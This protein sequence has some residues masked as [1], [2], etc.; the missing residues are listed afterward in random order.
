[1]F[2]QIFKCSVCTINNL[3]VIGNTELLNHQHIVGVSGSRKIDKKSAEWLRSTLK[4]LEP[5]V[6]VSGLA[7]GADTVAHRYGIKNKIKQIAILP[8]GFDNIYPKVN[9]KIAKQIIKDGG[10]LASQLPPNKK[11]SKSSFVKR[12][13]VIAD[14]SS[15]LII[16]QCK[17][18]SGTMHT[19]N[20][21]RN[22]NI[23]IIVQNADYSGNQF[24]LKDYNLS[25]S[26]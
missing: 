6:L 8:S 17:I 9:T 20:F 2:S 1:M 15:K 23:P 25:Q 18:K 21:A 7:F 11:A 3:Y 24:I 10:C 22:N 14:L 4:T 12:N 16:P 5:K 13:K 19:V 26:Q